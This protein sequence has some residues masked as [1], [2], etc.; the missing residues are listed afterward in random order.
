MQTDLSSEERTP[1]VQAKAVGE[2]YAGFCLGMA[3]PLMIFVGY[4]AIRKDWLAIVMACLGFALLLFWTLLRL[5]ES[6]RRRYSLLNTRLLACEADSV[7]GNG[8]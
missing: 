3:V 6:A 5:C 4:G 1:I 7:G 8:R 2:S